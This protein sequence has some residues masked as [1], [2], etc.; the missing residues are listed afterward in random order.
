MVKDRTRSIITF[1]YVE[2]ED[3]W[4]R[5]ALVISFSVRV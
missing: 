5:I 3:S 4:F 1:N 2:K